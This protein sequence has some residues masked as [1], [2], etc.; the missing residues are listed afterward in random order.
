MRAARSS[1]F[2][3]RSARFEQDAR[4]LRCLA[5]SSPL[6]RYVFDRPGDPRSLLRQLAAPHRSGPSRPE[7][8]LPGA[9]ARAFL[10]R[11]R[12]PEPALRRR[13]VHP[14]VGPRDRGVFLGLPPSWA[15]SGTWEPAGI[16]GVESRL[17]QESL[18]NGAVSARGLRVQQ[19]QGH[20]TVD[21]CL[22]VRSH[23]DESSESPLV[24]SSSAQPCRGRS[25]G[26]VPVV[27][28]CPTDPGSRRRRTGTPSSNA[29]RLA[30]PVDSTT[31]PRPFTGRT[32]P[33][34]H[35]FVTYPSPTRRSIRQGDRKRSPRAAPG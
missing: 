11:P 24:D 15:E 22:V 10:A 33:G 29:S 23:A 30:R 21:G 16:D 14:E 6:P 32:P 20:E 26:E 19:I 2:R 3:S 35:G 31:A 13:F 17:P 5:L 25:G 7:A 27:S 8:A 34:H 12:I 9:Y 4:S 28:D 1:R 18:L